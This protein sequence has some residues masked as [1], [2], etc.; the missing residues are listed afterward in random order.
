MLGAIIAGGASSRFGSDKAVALLDGRPLIDHAIE[1]IRPFVAEVVICGRA[2]QGMPGLADLPAPGLGPLGGINA[3][4]A[5]AFGGGFDHVLTI[6]CDMPRVPPALLAALVA[7]APAYCS[8]APILGCWPSSM[9]GALAERLVGRTTV[10]GKD[11]T[12]SIRRFAEATGMA[13]IP[14]PF[15]LENINTPAD[16]PA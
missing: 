8:D 2:W 5:H 9:A 7:R 11:R 1:A 15:P 4:L 3:A 6:G 10:R 13:A 12:L 16:I 14:A